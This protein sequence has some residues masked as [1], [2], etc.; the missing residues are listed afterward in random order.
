MIQ[1]VEHETKRR[2]IDCYQ[3][4]TIVLPTRPSSTSSSPLLHPSPLVLKLAVGG[5]DLFQ[6]PGTFDVISTSSFTRQLVDDHAVRDLLTRATF[7]LY[8][9]NLEPSLPHA[10]LSI[11]MSDAA[12]AEQ[13]PNGVPTAKDEL[14]ASAKDGQT[15]SDSSKLKTFLSILRRFIGVTDIASVRISL[16]A[17]LL[18]PIPNLE[19]WHYLDRPETFA[20]ISDSEDPLE[21]MLAC[22]RFW[23]TKDL[24]YVKGKPC[25]PYNSALGEFFRCTWEAPPSTGA[26]AKENHKINFL[27]EQTSHHPPVSAYVYE[28]P[29]K[30][31]SAVGY[32]QLSAKFTGTSVRVTPGQYNQGIFV[33]LANRGNEEYSMTH[34]A[35]YLNGF[36]RGSLY[37][38]VADICFIT[39]P[40]T[41][42]KTILHYLDE[43]YFGKTQNKVEGIIYKPANIA[44]DNI[45]KLKDVPKEQ[46]LGRIEGCWQEKIYYIPGSAEPKKTSSSD[47]VLLMDVTPLNPVPKSCPP[48]EAQL[49]NESR[50]FWNDITQAILTKQYG[51]ATT[52]KQKLEERQRERAAER[53]KAGTE[54]HP[55]FFTTVT[56]PDGRAKLSQEGTAALQGLQTG[57]F[58]LEE[59]SE[60]AAL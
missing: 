18:E 8:S 53:Q 50:K 33:T 38:T 25:K 41:G 20:A 22:L 3:H 5:I 16:P 51:Q 13:H 4:A 14:A 31:I 58:H 9:L 12:S 46:I 52:A 54:W 37:V 35:A 19:Y 47:K 30:G 55:R 7:S 10:Q 17:Q 26:T 60:Y 40:K 42:I 48:L 1:T 6:S 34:P 28:C 29:D 49:P 56:E 45:T 59:P 39:C 11:T 2:V 57:N 23:F 15:Q 32:D 21:R 36:F 43:G 44:A 27:C 24:K